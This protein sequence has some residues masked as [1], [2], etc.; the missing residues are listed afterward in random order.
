MSSDSK[1]RQEASEI[2]GN[3]SLEDKERTL[4]LLN[5]HG[6]S[7]PSL[8]AHQMKEDTIPISIDFKPQLQGTRQDVVIEFELV[9]QTCW[10]LH[11][12]L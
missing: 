12:E 4:R 9:V 11:T 2:V 1:S 8:W 6:R 3:A 7:D 10:S 5:F